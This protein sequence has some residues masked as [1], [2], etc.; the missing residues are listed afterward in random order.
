[1]KTGRLGMKT[2]I[3]RLHKVL[4]ERDA[5]CLPRQSGKTFSYCHD[6]AGVIEVTRTKRLIVIVPVLSRIDHI[7]PMLKWVLREHFIHSVRSRRDILIAKPPDGRDVV[8]TFAS[9]VQADQG[10]LLGNTAPIIVFED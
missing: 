1:M 3:D 6:V 7:I 8:I 5:G 9:E 2:D 10:M 4:E